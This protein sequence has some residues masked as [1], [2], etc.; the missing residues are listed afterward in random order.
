[1]DQAPAP[2]AGFRLV[3][4]E[5]LGK[6][7]LRRLHALCIPIGLLH[8][9]VGQQLGGLLALGYEP[10]ARGAIVVFVQP[11]QAAAFTFASSWPM[12]LSE[13]GDG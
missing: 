9:Q 2:G 10:G 1:V 5:Q 11:R 8:L 3:R 4:A 7:E 6:V 13:I 12:R